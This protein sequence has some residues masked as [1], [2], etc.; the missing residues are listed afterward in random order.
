MGRLGNERPGGTPESLLLVHGAGSGPWIFAGWES[1]FPGITISAIDL[2]ERID[3][4]KASMTYYAAV[5]TTA[6]QQLNPPVA[7]CGWSM[8]GLAVLHAAP[9]VKPHSVVLL[10]PS[11]PAEVQGFHPDTPLILGAYNPEEE[12][13]SFPPGQR[14]RPESLLARS[15][16]KRGISVPALPCRSLVVYGDALPEERGPRVAA[17]Y[18]SEKA[19]FPGLTSHWD[20]VL[21]SRVRVAISR[22]LGVEG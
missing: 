18:G 15:E 12:Y 14:S 21:E 2:Q 13:G 6:A 22:F 10:E 3:V 19:Y 16:R 1:A 5:V 7:L 9:A 8:G 4:G 11:P 20:L 17:C